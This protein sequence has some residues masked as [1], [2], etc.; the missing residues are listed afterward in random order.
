MGFDLWD[1]LG[2]TSTTGL[3]VAAAGILF[4]VLLALRMFVSERRSR[5]AAQGLRLTD[6]PSRE[7]RP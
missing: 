1:A 2:I 7:P 3:S 6:A 4:A 5:S